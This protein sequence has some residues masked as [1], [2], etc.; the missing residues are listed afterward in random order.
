MGGGDTESMLVK[1]KEN[2][3]GDLLLDAYKN[4]KVITGISA[5][6]IIWFQCGHSDSEWFK[7]PDNWNY[8]FVKG[9]DIYHAAFCPHYNESGRESFDD[10][11]ENLGIMGLALENDVAFVSYEGRDFIKKANEKAHAY[12]IK[13]NK[14]IKE[15][16]ELKEN[17]GIVLLK[18]RIN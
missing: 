16:M 2:N 4:D 18:T 6:A 5:G 11:L 3:V 15:K 12:L 8:K 1:W 14:S 7:D 17:E 10:M 13:Y 9:L